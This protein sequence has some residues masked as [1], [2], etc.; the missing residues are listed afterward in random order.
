MQRCSLILCLMLMP[1]IFSTAQ[2]TASPSPKLS[3]LKGP[4]LGQK[5]PGMMPEIFAPGIISTEESE[6]SSGFALNGTIFLFQRFIER[7]CHT[8]MMTRTDDVWSQP[9][10]VPFWEQLVHNGD[11]V[12]VPDDRTMLYQV[13]E[14]RSG[15]LQSDIWEVAL[16]DDGWGKRS[17]LPSPINTDHDE[18]FASRASNGNLYFFSRRPGGVGESDL[19]WSEY[20][21]GVYGDPI[22]IKKLNTVYHE[23][24]PFISPDESYMI[25]CSTKPDGSGRDDLYVSFRD[26]NNAWCPPV[27]MGE[28]FNSAGSENRPYVTDDGRFFFYT[29]SRT[30]NRDVYWVDARAIEGL[31]PETLR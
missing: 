21:N 14:E 19:Y 17:P 5:P 30:G 8:Y 3:D 6:G 1:L 16:E 2:E 23:W 4:Y 29:S 31:K 26:K 13:K 12:I 22:N 7:R 27:H 24:D 28:M 20:R 9:E 10:L 25:F 18:S 15:R 11:F